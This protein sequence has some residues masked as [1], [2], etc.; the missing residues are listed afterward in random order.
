MTTE[1]PLTTAMELQKCTGSQE[2]IAHFIN[3]ESKKRV[4]AFAVMV[5]KQFPAPVN[6]VML[7]TPKKN[8]PGKLEFAEAGGAVKFTVPE[9]GVYSMVVAE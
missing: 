6:A 2:V 3:F 4:G 1:T 7:F 8:D 9:K 5:K